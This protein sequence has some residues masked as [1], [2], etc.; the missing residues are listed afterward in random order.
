MFKNLS[1]CLAIAGLLVCSGHARAMDVQKLPNGA[2]VFSL[3]EGDNLQS[4]LQL[5]KL[6]D[7]IVLAAGSKY[8]GNFTLPAKPTQE[9]P[10]G[11]SPWITIRTSA[12]DQ[13]PPLGHRI[14]PE[15]AQSMP[16]I[17]TKNNVAAL[18]SEF[19]AHHFHFV[20]IEITATSARVN[21]LV[22]FGYQGKTDNQARTTDDLPYRIVFERCY[23][24]GNAEGN[25]RRG[26]A[27]N[28]RDFA[29]LDSCIS[30]FH[31]KGADSQ[32]LC[33]WNGTGPF[34][35]I[36]NYVEGAGENILFG[37]ADPKIPELVPSDIEV[38]R[39]HFFKPNHWNKNHP[40]Y[41]GVPWDVKNLFEIKNARRVH[42]VGNVFENCWV[43][44]QHGV[45]IVLTPR[46]QKGKAP[47]CTLEDVLFENNIVRNASTGIAVLSQDSPKNPSLSVKNV[48]VS[49]NLFENIAAKEC[50]GMGR[51]FEFISSKK[52]EPSRNISV[53]HNTAM[54]STE[55]SAKS[56]LTAGESGIAVEHFIF[57]HNIVMCG[58]YG[59]T[60]TGAAPGL[61][62][63][64]RFYR[65]WT[66]RKNILIGKI[67][68]KAYPDNNTHVQS[69][70][71]V[72]FVDHTKGDYRLSES[73]PYNQRDAEGQIPGANM[74][75]LLFATEGVIE[76]RPPR[77]DQNAP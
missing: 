30:E 11:R 48:R 77:D 24:H 31:E 43:Q 34:K 76:G 7:T 33:A 60:G 50:G 23:I 61:S 16:K 53:E 66:F 57:Q 14:T 35:I 41:G 59:L 69:L 21:D 10:S 19:Q 54:F 72:G 63:L 13:L 64:E 42:I 1:I 51:F 44:A 12:L 62:A 3:K 74:E 4:V 26:I 49:N 15:D 40:D 2:T 65:D 75:V 46:N 18:N 9:M 45:A 67:N 52:L 39:N 73:S 37:G 56:F 28:A 17:V 68:K 70:A 27:M 20:G 55:G 29:I 25:I 22:R 47:W 38:R 36:N 8:V 32:A 71:D 58:K 6:G 5:V